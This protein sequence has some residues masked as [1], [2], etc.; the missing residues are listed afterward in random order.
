MAPESIFS[1]ES[2][3]ETFDNEHPIRNDKRLVNK[4]AHILREPNQSVWQN[5]NNQEVRN[6]L[7]REV[8]MV[9]LRFPW[10]QKPIDL[11][12]QPEHLYKLLQEMNNEITPDDI[13]AY[14]QAQQNL[15][16]PV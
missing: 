13:R 15:H 4:I 8:P 16:Q 7:H 10:K 11:I 14:M 2:W 1:I 6:R 12:D 9:A 5:A 3:R